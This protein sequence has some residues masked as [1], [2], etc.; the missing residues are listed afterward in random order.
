MPDLIIIDEVVEMGF[1]SMAG[2]WSTS[3]V[4][5]SGGLESRNQNWA[6][7]RRRYEYAYPEK[8]ADDVRTIMAFIDDRRGA[9]YPWLLKDWLN[10]QLTDEVILDVGS[11]D[12]GVST[13]QVKQTWGPN[14]AF[15][16]D[17]KYIKSGTLVVKKNAVTLTLTTDYT[18]NST[19]LITFVAP[20]VAGDEI[21]VT[22]D[23]Y[24]KVRFEQ[25]SISPSIDNFGSA[26]I[27]SITA[28][29]VL[30]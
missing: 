10:F 8:D 18:V 29:E 22:C 14:N 6:A 17:I 13:A 15:S 23:F 20:L 11:G 7:P 1:T 27:Q 26:R 24:I 4:P 25:D 16:R 5:L 28:I 3:I 2:G 9:F 21:T 12:G 30:E 19:G